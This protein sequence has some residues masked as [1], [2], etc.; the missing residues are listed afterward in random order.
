MSMET[1]YSERCASPWFAHAF[2]RRLWVVAP[3]QAEAVEAGRARRLD[4]GSGE[5]TQR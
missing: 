5:R 2:D 1:S 4:V 3:G